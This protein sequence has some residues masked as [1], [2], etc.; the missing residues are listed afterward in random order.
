MGFVWSLE[1]GIDGKGCEFDEKRGGES[2]QVD[3]SSADGEE[4]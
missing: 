2:S 1:V 4:G 3:R